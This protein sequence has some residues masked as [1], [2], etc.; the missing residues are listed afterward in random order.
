MNSNLILKSIFLEKEQIKNRCS[1]PF[2]IEV[3]KNMDSI[4]FHAPVT[5]LIGENGIGKSTL[6]EAIAVSCGLNA[7]GGTQNFRFSHKTQL[8]F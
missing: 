6:I 4:Q 1:Y 2:S 3:I 5:F 8:P 7:E